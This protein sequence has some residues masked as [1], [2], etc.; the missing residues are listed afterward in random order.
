MAEDEQSP[1]RDSLPTE[2]DTVHAATV[3]EHTDSTTGAK[4]TESLTR[5][6]RERGGNR[7]TVTRS[8]GELDYAIGIKNVNKLKRL[9]KTLT[10]KCALLAEMDREILKLVPEDKVESEV[11]QSDIVRERIEDA[12]ME[13]DEALENLSL[14][15]TRRKSTHHRRRHRE[16]ESESSLSA[17]EQSGE[18]DQRLRE[19]SRPTSVSVTSTTHS[20]TT[21]TSPSVMFSSTTSDAVITL[22]EPITVTSTSSMTSSSVVMSA[23]HSFPSIT[24]THGS[25]FPRRVSF[26]EPSTWSFNPYPSF[27]DSPFSLFSSQPSTITSTN[28]LLG[29]ATAAPGTPLFVR[30]EP[31]STMTAHPLATSN[32]TSGAATP[33]FQATTEVT[34]TMP[35]LRPQVPYQT[36]TTSYVPS[37]FL[38]PHPWSAASPLPTVNPLSATV[39]QVRLPKLS[40]KPFDGNV[41]TWTTFWD[42]Y[43]AAIH[44]N[45]TLTEMDKFN[46]LRSMLR[47]SAYEAV[48]GLLLTAANYK[49]AVEILKRRFG[50]KQMIVSRHMDALMSLEAVASA[51][52]MVGL[53][54]L[55]DSVETHIR[56]LESLG[57]G[58]ETYGS[59]LSS[60]LL[61]KLPT[62]LKLAISRKLG[63]EE[64][65]L[66]AILREFLME[67]EARERSIGTTG[68][69]PRDTNG[70]PGRNSQESEPNQPTPIFLAGNAQ[71]RCSYCNQP[72]QSEKCQSVQE[73]E[74]RKQMLRT[75]GRCFVCLRR[76]HLSRQ[77]R[78]KSR[79]P[80]CRGRHHSSICTTS[81]EPTNS[82]SNTNPTPMNTGTTPHTSL[83]VG[84]KETVLLQTASIKVYNP[85]NRDKHVQIRAIFDTGSQQSYVTRNIKEALD[86]KPSETKAIT[87]MTFGCKEQTDQV[88]DVVKIGVET[89][90]GKGQEME[91]FAVP[92]ICQPLTTRPIDLNAS[93]CQH[94]S[95]LDMADVPDHE[96]GMSINLLIG[97]D[98]YWN[99]VTGKTRHGQEGPVAIHSKVGWML[100]GVVPNTTAST[101][102]HG[103]LTAHVLKSDTTQSSSEDLDEVL[104]SFW[105]LESLGVECSEDSVL[106]SF[107]QTIQYNEGRY[108]VTLPWKD[109][110]PELPTNYEL[111]YTRLQ[112]LLRRLK[113]DP[114]ILNEYDAI[115]GSQLQQEII[116]EVKESPGECERAH[117]LPHHAVIKRDKETT[118]V[119]IVYDASARST[120]CSLNE[121]LHK[122]PKFEQSILGILLRFRTH[123]VALIADIEKAF[124]MV[125]IDKNDRDFL[126]FLWVRDIAS[127]EPQIRI[128]R[129]CRAVFGVSSSPFLLNATVQHHLQQYVSSHPTLISKLTAS[130]YVDDIV[131]GAQDEQQAYQ[132]YTEAKMIFRAGGF[133]LRKFVTNCQ[134]IQHKIDVEEGVRDPTAQPSPKVI[135][136]PEETYS[137]STLG[138]SQLFQSGEQKVLGLRWEVATD[139]ICFGFTE[140]AQMAL[141]LEPTKRNL[142]ST[143]G[144]FYDPI[145]YL[146]PIVISFKILFQRLCQEKLEW[147]Q[148]LSGDL[149]RQ[150]NSLV[151]DLVLCPMLS[152]PRCIWD[153][154]SSQDHTSSLVGFCDASS[155]AYAAVVYLVIK[156]QQVIHVRFI[157]SKTRVAP[158]KSLTIP[159]LELLSGLLL[160]RLMKSVTNS[161]ETEIPLEEPLCYTDSEVALYWVT[162]TNKVWKQFVQRRVSEIRRLIDPTL[163]RHCSGKDNP[164]DL[165][166]RGIN[167]TELAHS[168]LWKEGPSWLGISEADQPTAEREMPV[169][170]TQELKVT[171]MGPL[172]ATNSTT[173]N[174]DCHDYSSLGK[175]LRVTA[176]VLRFITLLK[177]KI[178]AKHESTALDANHKEL[179]ADSIV[180]AETFWVKN[181]QQCLTS[182]DRFQTLK[183]QFGLFQDEDGVWRCGGRLANATISFQTKHPILLPTN[184]H[185][186]TLI[187]RRAHQRVLHNGVKEILNEI[188]A[189]FWIV[190]GRSFVKK[191]IHRCVT[192]RRF[193]GLPCRGLPPPP[194]PSFRLRQ[195]PPFTHTG[196]DFAGPLLVKS[197]IGTGSG[198]AWIA[199]YTCCVTRA[200]HLDIVPEMTTTAFIRSLKR[201]SSRRGLPKAF[202]SDNGKTFKGAARVIGEI[203]DDKRLEQHLSGVGVKWLFNLE[204]APWWGGI[205]ERLVRMTKRCLRKMVG[206]SRLTYDELIT[207]VCEVEGV[208]NARPLTYIT[209]DDLEEPLTPAHLITGRRVLNLPDSF[210]LEQ[211]EQ[212]DL[213]ISTK[214]MTERLTH[215]HKILEEF[216]RRWTTEYVLELREAHRHR[217]KTDEQAAVK[218]GDVVLVF[219]EDS[220]RGLWKIALV[221]SLIVGKDHQARGAILKVGTTGSREVNLRRP[222]QKLYP[223][224]VHASSSDSDKEIGIAN[225]ANETEEDASTSKDDQI[226]E[227]T[228]QAAET[229][230]LRRPRRAAAMEARS[231]SQAMAMFE[232][233]DL[234]D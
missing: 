163:W 85:D 160:A 6:L 185:I 52:N 210:Y 45:P 69:G 120:G 11:E 128:F 205:F 137:K 21:Q 74:Q 196:V 230:E 97:L 154:D 2:I 191:L 76:G 108:E 53:R 115:I 93:C 201:F 37:P 95:G 96:E 113:R 173:L 122:G 73:P 70:T 9:K 162:G 13:L 51:N 159:R 116:E 146:A 71:A 61:N 36:S 124:L 104:R 64:W 62:T 155:A 47:R 34:P 66:N 114:D 75:S 39:T 19:T 233:D 148:P 220:P 129:F 1:L 225:T 186:T 27:S 119:R 195:S 121:C 101:Q 138:M 216:W 145:G 5:K 41:T 194:L 192:C 99:F 10:E 157:A 88:C 202:V 14:P 15:A 197:T 106:D 17:S 217:Q 84:A 32:A 132:F 209:A 50:N 136:S 168:Q 91:L 180:R 188:R 23:P 110:H 127:E 184:H 20:P 81:S 181:A 86:L 231:R 172:T 63:G 25:G 100:S 40:I 143:I 226:G 178:K 31:I 26:T 3:P 200:I 58:A 193:E 109:S 8:I 87:V 144:W 150:W 224:E 169:D 221:K 18:D 44:D 92:L 77:C 29:S 12:L 135:C 229:S 48:S 161:L 177:N 103:L 98:Y 153:S 152:I 60:V 33:R 206:R 130:L 94:L 166:S 232:D 171:T 218:P 131:S 214:H 24:S 222:L 223:L 42:S 107:S 22:A 67:L 228:E 55:Y 198:K 207:A 170:C 65:G 72:H 187:A 117:Y 139:K 234:S 7:S 125:A 54:R 90:D 111:S 190:K 78:S 43:S 174:I 68:K 149:L 176:Y 167:P 142:V 82:Q 112:G 158:M 30:H 38:Q 102:R 35:Q 4:T 208:L 80:N 199:L 49:E 182:E 213:E 105:K 140:I 165:P 16:G 215:L 175:L 183:S 211:V 118:K 83:L 204:R 56:G 179:L 203:L 46:Y 89:R 151:S 126:R 141:K 57:V 164:A 189:K 227:Q 123:R 59:L 133:N 134:A 219:D 79:C 156:T 212:G 147:D 28:T